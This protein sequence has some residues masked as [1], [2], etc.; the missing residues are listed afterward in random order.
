MPS[1]VTS[2]GVPL[3][4]SMT[5]CVAGSNMALFKLMVNVTAA[6]MTVVHSFCQ[7]GQLVGCSGSVGPS[8]VCSV[9]VSLFFSPSCF[10]T[11]SS[12]SEVAGN[13]SS[14]QEAFGVGEDEA[15]GGEGCVVKL[16]TGGEV[17]KEGLKIGGGSEFMLGMIDIRLS[18][19]SM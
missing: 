1:K 16:P 14:R 19:D 6:S 3:N 11:S 18:E 13:L 2:L 4:S 5:S 17:K 9:C 15:A 8:Q 10:S 12:S 7:R